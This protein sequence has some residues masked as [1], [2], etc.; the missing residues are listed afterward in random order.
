M[1]KETQLNKKGIIK[2]V[3]KEIKNY[4]SEFSFGFMIDDKWYNVK[5]KDK[6]AIEKISREVLQ[7][8]NEIQFDISKDGVKNITLISIGI[9]NVQN[10]DHNFGKQE[11][12]SKSNYMV[13]IKGKE[14]VTYAGLLNLAHK[15]S[16][17]ENF[18]ILEVNVSEDMK[19][20]WVKVRL[21]VK[22]GRFFDGIGS[23]TPENTGKMTEDHPIEMAHTRAKAR[24]LRDFC[25]VGETAKEELKN[26]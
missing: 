21:H 11:T 8:G 23:S 24:A 9:P 1:E 12:K 3:A 13:N 10:Y 14:Y 5:N 2:A 4:G 6:E 26:H 15:D 19:R 7:R 22:G 25:N 16:M 20:A 18:E 17:L